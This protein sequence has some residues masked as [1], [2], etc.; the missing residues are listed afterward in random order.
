MSGEAG[1][2]AGSTHQHHNLGTFQLSAHALP[3]TLWE[4]AGSIRRIGALG[5]SLAILSLDQP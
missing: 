3:H 1:W 2:T 4:A 5:A